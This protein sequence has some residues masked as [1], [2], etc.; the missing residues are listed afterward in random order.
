MVIVLVSNIV[1]A[2]S[3]FFIT[4]QLIY[5]VRDSK[6]SSL[7]FDSSQKMLLSKKR[8]R[9]FFMLLGLATL[10]ASF[11]ALCGLTHAMNAIRSFYPS[12]V[13]I[14]T[15]QTVLLVICAVVSLAT[16]VVCV[17]ICPILLNIIPKFEL[18]DEG[19]L[20]HAES[21]MLEI[22]EMVK[23]SIMVISSDLKIVRMNEASK[24]LFGSHCL[25]GKS[26][27]EFIHPDDLPGFQ[28]CSV[29]ALVNYG[30]TPMT[31]EYRIKPA[32]LVLLPSRRV[33]AS[34]SVHIKTS[35]VHVDPVKP[36]FSKDA[37]PF[38]QTS[39]MGSLLLGSPKSQPTTDY[40]WVESTILKHVY[41]DEDDVF[42][43][44]LEMVS[45]NI[46]ERR[47]K[48]QSQFENIL[49]ETEE[50]SR[51]NAA[52]MRY[53]SCIAHDLKTP[54]QSFCYT[55]DLLLQ[56]RL[57]SDQVELVHEAD[58]AVDLMKLTI[59][60]TMDVSKALTGAKLMPRRTTVYLSSVLKRVM[61]IM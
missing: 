14:E 27:L 57:H 13:T 4:I 21:Y 43:G 8:M 41:K 24:E 38:A 10:F 11:I 52:K 34:S 60:Q 3:Y 20:E 6:L 42:Q 55:L 40:I 59:S 22:V 32:A 28:T 51:I 39:S 19:I 44:T 16:A 9:P 7:F 29:A 50:Q 2:V 58:V 12:F 45:R 15:V 37:G 30:A 31:I 46:D 18:N 56:T 48:H 61:I 25:A 53:L 1:V 47:R 33:P 36:V 49:K 17:K 5:F 35:R 26:M 23:E 54:L